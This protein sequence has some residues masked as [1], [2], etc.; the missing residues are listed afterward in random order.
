[1]T[2]SFLNG[3]APANPAEATA[4]VLSLP[5]EQQ[6]QHAGPLIEGALQNG[7]FTAVNAVLERARDAK[8][9]ADPLVQAV[10]K[11]VADR[12]FFSNWVG[13]TPER[14]CAWVLDHAGQPYVTP[15]VLH[16]AAGDYAIKDPLAAM[17]WVDTNRGHFNEQAE[18]SSRARRGAALD[19][20]WLRRHLQL[21]RQQFGAPAL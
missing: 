18:T 9:P 8:G 17:Q 4:F 21:A 11:Q 1:M 15:D 20:E 2:G 12:V 19:G 16:H 7:G 13:K 3:M 10:F 6:A 5:A 14:A